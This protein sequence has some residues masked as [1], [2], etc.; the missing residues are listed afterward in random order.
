MMDE[1]ERPL[2]PENKPVPTIPPNQSVD[3]P[4]SDRGS[5][6]LSVAPKAKTQEVE[7]PEGNHRR[8]LEKS[9]LKF[10]IALTASCTAVA[11]AVGVVEYFIPSPDAARTLT[12]TADLLKLLATTALGFIFGRSLSKSD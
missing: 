2:V 10:A 8:E 4:P 7:D 3:E 1:P 5:A 6:S 11:V 9:K 12:S